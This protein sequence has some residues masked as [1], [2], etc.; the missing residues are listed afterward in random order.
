[1]IDRT[2]INFDLPRL[3]RRD[4]PR[5]GAVAWALLAMS[6]ALVAGIL[7]AVMWVVSL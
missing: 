6:L 3:D 2:H 4:D 5:G 7:L 1:M